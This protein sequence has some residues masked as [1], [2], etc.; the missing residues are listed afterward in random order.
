[1]SFDVNYFRPEFWVLYG[2]VITVLALLFFNRKLIGV[3]IPIL[4]FLL[5]V[6]F[7]TKW[8]GPYWEELNLIGQLTGSTTAAASAAAIPDVDVTVPITIETPPTIEEEVVEEPADEAESEGGEEEE[9]SEEEPAEDDDSDEDEDG[10][11]GGGWRE[12]PCERGWF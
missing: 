2:A 12:P 6:S 4:A 5:I 10:D 1:M 3:G 9:P 7:T 11:D 8:W